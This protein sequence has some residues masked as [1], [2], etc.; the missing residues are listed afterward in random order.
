MKL[1]YRGV[2]YDAQSAEAA[3]KESAIVAKYR[4]LVYRL[5][6]TA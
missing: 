3:T 2:R 4:G 6:T 1:F 5:R